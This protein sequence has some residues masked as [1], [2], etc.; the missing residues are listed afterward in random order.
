M[1]T[2]TSLCTQFK[3]GSAD[4][5]SPFQIKMSMRPIFDEIFLRQNYVINILCR[6]ILQLKYRIYLSL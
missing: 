5:S 6:K 4:D 3:S 2:L 1:F